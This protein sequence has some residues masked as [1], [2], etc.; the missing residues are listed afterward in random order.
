MIVQNIIDALSL[1]SVYALLAL[2]IALVFGI[3]RLINFAHG[4][5]LMIAGYVLLAFA[6][7]PVWLGIALAI[8]IP[9]LIAVGMERL[10]FRPVRG[11]AP[12]TLLMTSFAVSS[13]I[14]GVALLA[15]GSRAKSVDVLPSLSRAVHV[16]GASVQRLDLVIVAVTVVLFAALAAFLRRTPLG[17]QMRAAAEDFSMA[18]AL[19]VPANRVI[20]S[21][22]AISGLLAGVAAVLYV[23]RTGAL[24]PTMGLTP[25]LIGFV[26]TV[27][28]GVGTFWASAIGGYVLGA[29]T[30]LLQAYLPES[31]LPYRD[32][33]VFGGVILLLVVRPQGIAGQPDQVRV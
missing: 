20:A 9:A 22:F 15:E 24:T 1:G 16:A 31:L 21:A 12:M 14:Q 4:E 5:L 7:L 26:A 28:G 33:F 18:R 13:L 17:L 6:G 10:A 3:M 8:F 25:V 30:V 11:A 2:G 29:M 27:I 23:A 19:G 32:A